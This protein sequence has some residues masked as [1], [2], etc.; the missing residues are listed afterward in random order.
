MTN[1]SVIPPFPPASAPAAFSQGPLLRSL[2]G[3]LLG[4]AAGVALG[5]LAARQV[6]TPT[7]PFYWEMAG[8]MGG[9]RGAVLDGWVMAG[10]GRGAA[11]PTRSDVNLK[12]MAV[13]ALGGVLGGLVGGTLDGSAIDLLFGM[14][15]GL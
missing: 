3:S 8:G 10:E 6:K 11:G 4:A 13:V 15:W 5:S 12:L 1:T 14:L 2:L 9:V 7:D